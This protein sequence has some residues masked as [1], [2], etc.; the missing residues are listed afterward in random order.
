MTKKEF[1]NRIINELR[2]RG[3]Q[4]KIDNNEV[5]VTYADNYMR[6]S[7]NRN[8]VKVYND[9]YDDEEFYPFEGNMVV[10]TADQV[11]NVIKNS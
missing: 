4:S 7:C 8:F 2:L 10:L 9:S 11:E 5:F 6:I 3:Y 1:Y